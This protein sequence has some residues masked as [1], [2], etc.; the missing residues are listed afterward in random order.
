M[1]C[2]IP[3][4][5]IGREG[6]RSWQS[7]YLRTF[8]RSGSNCWVC[9]DSG[10]CLFYYRRN[11]LDGTCRNRSERYTAHD[12]LGASGLH[13][14]VRPKLARRWQGREGRTEGKVGKHSSSR[15]GSKVRKVYQH[16]VIAIRRISLLRKFRSSSPLKSDALKSGSPIYVVIYVCNG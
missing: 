8:W 5:L 10:G 14:Q 7:V 13:S 12:A 9:S 4:S 1:Q 15:R 11:A 6:L 2:V 16:V 3:V